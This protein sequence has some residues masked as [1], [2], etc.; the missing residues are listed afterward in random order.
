MSEAKYIVADSGA[1]PWKADEAIAGIEIKSLG[2]ANGQTMELCRYAPNTAY[3][4]HVHKGPE[5]VF[6]IE[7]QARL[8][9][10][11]LTPGCSSVG[12]AGSEDS[13]FLSGEEG[14]LFLAVFTP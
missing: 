6:M 12:E 14:C 11:W 3:P 4:Y 1:L 7:G 13:D 5:F 8:A 10:Q 2:T 9:G